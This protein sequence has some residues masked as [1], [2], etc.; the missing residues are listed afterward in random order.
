MATMLI[1]RLTSP[2]DLAARLDQIE[3]DGGTIV[4]VVPAGDH[5][6]VVYNGRVRQTRQ[7]RTE[8]R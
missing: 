8:T 3:K 2:L 6:L 4:Q 5:Y 1:P 7:P